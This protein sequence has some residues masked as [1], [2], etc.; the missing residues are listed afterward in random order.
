MP[1]F[2]IKYGLSGGFGGTEFQEWEEITAHDLDEANLIAYYNACDQ[3][4]SCVGLHGLRDIDEIMEED[5]VDEEE[6]EDIYREE[7]EGWVEYEAEPLNW[8][9]KT[10]PEEPTVL[11]NMCGWEGVEEDLEQFEDLSG[12]IFKGCPHCETDGY[13]MDI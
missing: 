9:G 7:R 11:C 1:K 4:D 5:E 13:L 8:E 6:A 12:E 10:M 3:Y 2:K